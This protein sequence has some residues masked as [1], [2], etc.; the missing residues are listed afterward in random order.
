MVNRAVTNP[1]PNRSTPGSLIGQRVPTWWEHPPS[2]IMRIFSCSSQLSA[3]CPIP[4]SARMVG[5]WFFFIFLA[6]QLPWR[7]CPLFDGAT[8]APCMIHCGAWRTLQDMLSPCSQILK[9]APQ[10]SRCGTC[11]MMKVLF[12]PPRWTPFEWCVF[13]E[14]FFFPSVLLLPPL[15]WSILTMNVPVRVR[16]L[17]CVLCMTCVRFFQIFTDH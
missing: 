1:T 14:N 10:W 12:K 16:V 2:R 13:P 6:C 4:A 5:E 3:S 7:S 9:E 17:T 11:S 15:F 8:L